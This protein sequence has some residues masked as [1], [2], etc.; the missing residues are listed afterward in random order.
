M[1]VDINSPVACFFAQRIDVFGSLA[2]LLCGNAKVIYATVLKILFTKTK[3]SFGGDFYLIT[4]SP[5][6]GS[7]K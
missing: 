7:I 3:L 2:A 5:D 6:I 4:I 1:T